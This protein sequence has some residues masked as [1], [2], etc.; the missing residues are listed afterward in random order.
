MS[1]QTTL[2][3]GCGCR[4]CMEYGV[5]PFQSDEEIDHVKELLEKNKHKEPPCK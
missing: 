2:K 5:D 3:T 4:A 1:Y